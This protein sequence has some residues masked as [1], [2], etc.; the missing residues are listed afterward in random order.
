MAIRRSLVERRVALR[1]IGVTLERIRAAPTVAQP[2]LFPEDACL[3]RENDR[4]AA[5]EEVTE[6]AA[7]ADRDRWS[8][9]LG[10]LDAI[11][12]RHG[13]GA[14]LRGGALQWLD[15]MEKDRHG[16]ILRTSS[17]TR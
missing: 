14:V 2:E 9:L 3:I 8:R 7:P 15:G 10:S 6:L 11:R 13:D 1:F 16:L 17:L 5:R 12:D 4:T